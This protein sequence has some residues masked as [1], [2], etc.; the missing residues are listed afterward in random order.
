[1]VGTIEEGGGWL[2]TK[3]KDMPQYHPELNPIGSQ[4]KGAASYGPVYDSYKLKH[5]SLPSCFNIV[6]P[7]RVEKLYRHADKVMEDL[8]Q[9][10]ATYRDMTNLPDGE[11]MSDRET[12]DSEE[13]EDD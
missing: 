4:V 12:E 9:E 1:M 7:A 11:G 10:Y 8:I 6:T 2:G 13:D 5:E 3:G